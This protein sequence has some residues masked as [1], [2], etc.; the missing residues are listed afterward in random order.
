MAMSG[1]ILAHNE[2][3]IHCVMS[4]TCTGTQPIQLTRSAPAFSMMS[5]GQAGIQ[6]SQPLQRKSIISMYPSCAFGLTL[7]MAL[8]RSVLSLVDYPSDGKQAN[9]LLII[10]YSRPRIQ[11]SVER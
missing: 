7:R 4:V 9:D 1:Q 6:R 10:A 5:T 11:L 3:A 8:I 2:Q